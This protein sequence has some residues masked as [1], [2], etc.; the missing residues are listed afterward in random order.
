MSSETIIRSYRQG[1]IRNG[2]LFDENY[3]DIMETGIENSYKYSNFLEKLLLPQKG[4]LPITAEL[5]K[6]LEV[7]IYELNSF[8]SISLPISPMTGILIQFSGVGKIQIAIGGEVQAY[9]RTY[10]LEQDNFSNWVTFELYG[11]A[12]QALTN[13]KK[14]T[15]EKMGTVDEIVSQAAITIDQLVPGLQ[16]PTIPANLLPSY[17]DDIEDYKSLNDFPMNGESGKIYLD[18]STNLVY[19]WG[20]DTYVEISP[21]LALGTTS[22]TAFRGNLGQIAYDHAN[23]RGVGVELGLYKIATNDQGHVSLVNEIKKEDIVKLGIPEQDTTYNIATTTKDGLVPKLV[24]AQ[25]TIDNIETNSVLTNNNGVLGWYK[26]PLSIFNGSNIEVEQILTSGIE[27][28]AITVD[29]TRILLYAPKGDDE[30]ALIPISDVEI[31]EICIL[32][33]EQ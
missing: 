26:L 33:I 17:V 19:R 23:S 30:S 28:G 9:Y 25:N 13:A 24:T 1:D 29:G 18:T 20:G 10:N 4:E 16:N 2:Q 5:T 27:I 8:E 14:Y 22:S 21:S 3:I 11:S 15:D 12:E 7:G 32:P 31:D 6:P